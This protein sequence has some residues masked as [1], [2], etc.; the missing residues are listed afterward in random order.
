MTLLYKNEH[1][2]CTNYAEEFNKVFTLMEIPEGHTV[3]RRF[4]NT[5]F[6]VILLQG[7]IEIRY[8]IDKYFTPQLG[9][10]FLLPRNKQ[11]T[12]FARKATILLLCSFANDLKLCSR[13]SIQQLSR[14]IS[15]STYQSPYC[16]KLDMRLQSFFSLLVDC[17][18][19]G[20]G[21]IHYHQIKRDE[22]FLYLRAGYTKEEL[23]LFFY[24]VLGQ[25]LEFKD[26]VLMN[27][28][29]IFDVKDFALQ[30]NM[31]QSTFN[32][33]FKETFNETA[34]NWLLLRKQEFVKRDVALSN[35]SFSEIAEKYKF[36]STS[37]LVTFCKKY[38]GK[39]PNKIRKEAI[40]KT[41]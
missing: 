35:L 21:C 36:S 34:K 39:T 15:E 33:R 17:L 30:A 28:R 27:S 37:Y 5:T 41:V 7:D 14:F 32:R 9:Y 23:A 40:G 38:F 29:K 24:P 20:L 6:L 3:E 18:K 4:L 13:F 22:L 11:I 10:M 12:T 8:E 16:L 25:N 26:F 19:E 1:I 2:S 31:S